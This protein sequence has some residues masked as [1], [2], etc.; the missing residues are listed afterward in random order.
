MDQAQNNNQ[1]EV[2]QAP[3]QN[4]RWS[5]LAVVFFVASLVALINLAYVDD[6]IFGWGYSRFEGDIFLLSLLIFLPIFVI[7]SIA[8]LVYVT[9]HKLKGK[10]FAVISLVVWSIFLLLLL[11]F[12]YLLTLNQ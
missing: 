8:N 6:I 10:V 7:V 2:P 3:I 5:K 9:K 11:M 12:F 1:P 4:K